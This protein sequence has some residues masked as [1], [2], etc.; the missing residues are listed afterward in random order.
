MGGLLSKI[1]HKNACVIRK[2]AFKVLKIFSFV[3]SSKSNVNTKVAVGD[4]IFIRGHCS[5]SRT[6][7]FCELVIIKVEATY[8]LQILDIVPALLITKKL[9][10]LDKRM[11]F[12]YLKDKLSTLN[13]VL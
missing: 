10:N 7:Y 2:K 1:F 9:N 4:S 13:F 8:S 12:Y 5:N 11:P 3:Y 6:D